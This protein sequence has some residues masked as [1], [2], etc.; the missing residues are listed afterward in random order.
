LFNNHAASMLPVAY[1]LSVTGAQQTYSLSAYN[2]TSAFAMH[3]SEVWH[4]HFPHYAT[5]HGAL[6]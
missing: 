1:S 4:Q 2:R 3:H 6:L 5:I